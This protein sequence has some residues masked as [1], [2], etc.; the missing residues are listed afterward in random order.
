VKIRCALGIYLLENE[1]IE[2]YWSMIVRQFLRNL[3]T[4]GAFI[5]AFESEKQWMTI[6]KSFYLAIG[7]L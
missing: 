6:K 5:A 4:R 1:E 2:A 7:Y 3:Q